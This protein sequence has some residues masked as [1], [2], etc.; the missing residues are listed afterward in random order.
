MDKPYTYFVTFT[1]KY[2][3]LF[4]VILNVISDCPLWVCRNT[5]DFCILIL[6]LQSW[7]MVNLNLNIIHLPNSCAFFNS[8]LPL[9]CNYEKIVDRFM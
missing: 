3:I 1:H 4:V 6:F 2:F 9:D 8:V 7:L 5:I